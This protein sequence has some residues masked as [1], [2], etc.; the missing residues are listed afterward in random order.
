MLDNNKKQL[1]I[2]QSA[3]SRQYTDLEDKRKPTGKLLRR[4][5]GN[6]IILD[7]AVRDISG[8]ANF[9]TLIKTAVNTILK[10]GNLES[11]GLYLIDEAADKPVISFHTEVGGSLR[12][13]RDTNPLTAKIIAGVIETG[14]IL[15]LSD[16]IC[17]PPA[18]K[19]QEGT[20]E[21]EAVGTLIGVPLKSKGRIIGIIVGESKCRREFSE[22][23]NHFLETLGCQIGTA[24]DYARLIEKMERISIIDDLTG[25][26]NRRYLEEALETEIY[27]GQRCG[28]PFSLVM[29]DLDRFNDHIDRFGHRSGDDVLRYLSCVMKSALRKTDIACRYDSDK[30]GI[31]LPSTDAQ[32]AE[33]FVERIRSIFFKMPPVQSGLVQNP[34]GITAGIAQFPEA[35]ITSQGLVF[36]AESALRY[37]GRYG[38]NKSV[39]IADLAM[40]GTGRIH[41][42]PQQLFSLVNL[43]EAKEPSTLGHAMNVSIVSERLGKAMGLPDEALSELRSAALLHDVGKISVPDSILAKPAKLTGEEWEIVRNHTLEGARIIARVAEFRQ[44]VSVVKHHHEK[45]NG[46]GYPGGLSGDQIPL[47][48]RIIAIAD[49]YDTMI[50]HRAYSEAVSPEDALDEIRRCSGT[51]FDPQL[52]ATLLGISHSLN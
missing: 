18:V 11:A 16:V 31:I 26:Y 49:S 28:C 13:A 1:T 27:R 5:S 36:L 33:N 50:H 45:Y 39:L 35:A 9:D 25:L 14:L 42:G 38:G 12:K 29:M 34:V 22:E 52:V 24:L 3:S 7:A 2:E 20:P 4:N 19:N 21:A 43:V 48:S 40:L 23:D 30:F 37:A 47:Y 17:I 41:E 46:T 32:K 44:L 51:H 6:F 10:A 15:T 8:S